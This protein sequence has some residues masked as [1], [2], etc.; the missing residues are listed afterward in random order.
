MPT[1]LYS[2]GATQEHVHNPPQQKEIIEHRACLV[3][4]NR[5]VSFIHDTTEGYG[6]ENFEEH[7]NLS[8][9]TSR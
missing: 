9:S 6:N 7:S 3:P 4:S 2:S 1:K 8:V 5:C